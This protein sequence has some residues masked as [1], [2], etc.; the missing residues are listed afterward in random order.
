MR[1]IEFNITR[2]SQADFNADEQVQLVT[3]GSRTELVS[4]GFK[5]P[6]NKMSIQRLRAGNIV[7]TK[8]GELIASK[9]YTMRLDSPKGL[10]KSLKELYWLIAANVFGRKDELLLTLTYKEPFQLDPQQAKRD[11]RIFYKKHL[12]PNY[13]NVKY[14]AIFE[15]QGIL[16]VNPEGK[17][18]PSW[19]IHVILLGVESISKE[20]LYN[21]WKFGKISFI[22]I[23]KMKREKGINNL[24]EYFTSYARKLN[25]EFIND[26]ALRFAKGEGIDLLQSADKQE[27]KA[28]RLYFYPAKFKI[29]THSSGLKKAKKFSLPFRKVNQTIL[30]KLIS[31]S[32][33]IVKD[34]NGKK[35]NEYKRLVFEHD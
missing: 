24:A 19:H 16:H 6:R 29:F 28:A 13:P 7:N 26:L 12:H 2:K 20:K 31:S 3:A 11:W 14:I 9:K 15:P 34:S 25:P 4:F 8:T 35:L 23:G 5:T 17:K 21:W 22:N 1:S 18:V 32:T 33:V 30:G 27:A 10:K